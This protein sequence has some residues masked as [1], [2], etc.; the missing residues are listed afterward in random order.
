MTLKLRRAL[1]LWA[2]TLTLVLLVIIP[3]SGA[4]RA[5]AALAALCLVG[6]AWLRAD[7]RAAHTSAAFGLSDAGLLPPPSYRHPVMLVCGDGLDALFGVVAADQ[8]AVRTTSQGCYVRVPGLEQL[9]AVAAALDTLR[10]DWHGQISVMFIVNP[11]AHT[12]NAALAGR[13]RA[14]SYQVALLRKRG[15]A[16]PLLLVSY[17]LAAQ[18]EGAWFGWESDQSSL[19]VREDGT[20][21]SLA[22]WQRQPAAH[23]LQ[24]T[25]MRTCV[26]LNSAASW[27]AERVLPYLVPSDCPP[28]AC[29]ITFVPTLPESVPGHL[30]QQWLHDRTTLIDEDE[31][32][33]GDSALLPFP[34]PLLALLPTHFRNEPMIRAGVLA[35]WLSALA[36]V[37]ALTSSAWENKLLVRQVTDDLRRYAAIPQPANRDGPDFGRRED[38]VTV[39]R[40]DAL[41]L[42]NYYRQGE[43]LG[44]GLGLYRGEHLRVPLLNTIS[45]HRLP[46][47]RSSRVA[48]NPVRLDSLSL[49][50]IGSARLKPD[51]TKVLIDALVDIKAQSGWLIVITGHTDATGNPEQNVQLSRARAAAVRDWMQSM[52]NIPGSCFAVQGL[53]ANRPIA[54]NDTETGR[55]ANRRVDIRLVPE[56]GACAP[57]AA[58][59]DRQ[60]VA[61]RD[62]Q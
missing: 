2:G 33:P 9:P 15:I 44:L 19:G 49:F 22:D 52:G 37:V 47:E 32:A 18:G 7:R 20:H 58:V 17:L 59:P 51:S 61:S 35:L 29:A 14:F 38:A 45:R 43:P 23:A 3:L 28:L 46:P 42:D 50:A 40:R 4:T 30:W 34:D 36:G 13:V 8:L 53:G 6:L 10:P 26:Q 62:I 24:T 60:P 55:T 41:R 27:L 31:N 57:L 39:L 11:G 25:R 12:D 54:T 1:L 5:M 16:L 56:V 21:L 48:D